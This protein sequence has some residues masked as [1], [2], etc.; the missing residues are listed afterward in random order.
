MERYICIHGHFYQPPGKTRGSNSLNCSGLGLSVSRLERTDHR[1]VLRAQRH[2]ANSRRRR[3][4]CSQIS[5]I[6]TANQLQLRTDAAGLGGGEGTGRVPDDSRGRQGKPVSAFSGHGSAI[7]QAYNHYIL[8]LSQQPRQ[9]HA[10]SVGHSRL[11]V[12]LRTRT[13]RHVAAG[14][15]GR[16]G[17]RSISWPNLGSGSRSCR[18]TRRNVVAEIGG[19]EH[20]RMSTAAAS[21]RLDAYDVTT[22]SGKHDRAS[23]SMTARS[24]RLSRSKACWNS[25][26]NLPSGCSVHSRNHRLASDCAYRN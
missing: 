16:S 1:R 17:S 7:A 23:S 2:V 18:L 13:G 9:V 21:I 3:A 11:R 22:P 14:N 10:D 24:L 5:S 20:G 25:G 4:H 15:G 26:E 8:P 19:P 6:T 12:S